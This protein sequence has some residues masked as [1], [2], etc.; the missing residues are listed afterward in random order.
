MSG[1][2]EARGTVTS[3]VNSCVRN[4]NDRPI[5]QT[6]FWP[7]MAIPQVEMPPANQSTVHERL[8]CG[9][10][11]MK[12]PKTGAMNRSPPSPPRNEWSESAP[13]QLQVNAE[14]EFVRPPPCAVAPR[15]GSWLTLYRPRA[16]LDPHADPFTSSHSAKFQSSVSVHAWPSAP[17]DSPSE[18]GAHVLS[19][20]ASTIM[21]GPQN[22]LSTVSG[23]APKAENQ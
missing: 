5:V 6:K 16:S 21:T 15:V 14:C 1:R 13:E 9:E 22:K 23:P 2:Y 20:A 8:R 7:R 10:K 11:S 12:V 19:S 18:S 3:S 4:A 17:L